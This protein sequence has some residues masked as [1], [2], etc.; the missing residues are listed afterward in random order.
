MTYAYLLL[1]AGDSGRAALIESD[2]Q[3]FTLKE[4]Q[5]AVGGNIEIVQVKDPIDGRKLRIVIDGEGKLKGKRIS[6]RASLLYGSFYDYIAG[7]AILCKEIWTE[8]GPDV[9]K[10]ELEE[11]RELQKVINEKLGGSPSKT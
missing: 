3:E 4:L 10:L 6:L 5:K 1:K 8:D 2:R 7:D 9:G 11:A